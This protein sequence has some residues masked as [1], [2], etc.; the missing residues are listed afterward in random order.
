MRTYFFISCGFFLV[1]LPSQVRPADKPPAV[2]ITELVSKTLATNPEIRFYEA[3]IAAAKAGCVMAGRLSNPELS[4]D[5]GQKRVRGSDA[6]AEGLAYSVKL[7]QPIEWPGRLGLR[8][9]IANRDI[10]LA[11]L[12]LERFR[13]FLAAKV[14]TL[15][16][17]LAA[18]QENAEAAAEVADLFTSVREVIVQRETGGIAPVLE[19]KI[20]EATEVVVQRKAGEAAVE[21]Q[22]ALLEINQLMGRRADTS[23]QVKRTEFP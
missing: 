18:Q 17:A 15:G 4:F 10:A 19:A 12:G 2:G 6:N 23:L 9:A 8:K 5:L 21:M 3:E 13:A 20:I 14:K 22:K 1:I 7:A 11:E 16:Y